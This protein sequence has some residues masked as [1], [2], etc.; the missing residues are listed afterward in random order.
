MVIWRA[1]AWPNWW[2]TCLTKVLSFFLLISY[3]QKKF[4]LIIKIFF[5]EK[6]LKSMGP[7][8]LLL[9]PKQKLILR[10]NERTF[11]NNFCLFTPL[12]KSLWSSTGL[13][14]VCALSRRAFSSEG[15]KQNQPK[16]GSKKCLNQF[17]KSV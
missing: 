2:I 7:K 9:H 5:C 15:Q 4:T 6:W 11:I 17:W 1:A 12:W 14:L 10:K 8:H 3:S 13:L 16:L